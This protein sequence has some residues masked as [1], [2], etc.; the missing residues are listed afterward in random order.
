VTIRVG[1]FGANGRMGQT[2]CQAV[3]G[4]PDLEVAARMDIGDERDTNIDVAID[5]THAEGA[6]ENARWCADNGIHAV[7]GTS[8]ITEED[9]SDF[10]ARFTR[11]NCLVAPNFAIGAVLMTRLAELA[12]PHFDT[13]D[14]I[15]MHHD[16]KIDAPSGT[17]V[18]TAERIASASSEWA[19]D[20]TTKHTLPNARGAVGA[21]GIH[22]HSLRVRGMIAS[23]EVILGT[24]GQSLTIRHDTFDRTSFMPGVLLAAKHIADHPGLTIGLDSFLGL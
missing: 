19:A 11:S 7:I 17:A 15:E 8:G 9:C 2:V 14:V 6:R 16:G 23:Q 4:D 1:V 13:V 24:T 21:G 5:F 10:A 22:V 12:A 3:D 18:H 20:P